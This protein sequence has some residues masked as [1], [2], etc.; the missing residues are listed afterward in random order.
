MTTAPQAVPG[1]LS[2][3][4]LHSLTRQTIKASELDLSGLTVLTEAAS[5]SCGV[6][7]VAAAMANAK[8]VYAKV[9]PTSYG[10]VAEV[11]EWTQKLAREGGVQDQVW[12][13]R[14]PLIF[15]EE[16]DIVTNS[17][18]LRPI[19]AHIVREAAS[20]AVI[21]LMFEHGNFDRMI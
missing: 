3:G 11:T 2:V 5:G 12:W 4:R 14:F 8:K 18:H 21:A 1:A 20:A 9:R 16:V 17:G 15:W 13:K 6:T 10:S 7:A 19:S